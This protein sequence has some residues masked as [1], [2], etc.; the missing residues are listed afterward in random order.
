MVWSDVLFVSTSLTS[1]GTR[2]RLRMP[3][4]KRLRQVIV[5][6]GQRSVVRIE[7]YEVWE[8]ATFHDIPD[9]LLLIVM[10]FMGNAELCATALVCRHLRGLRDEVHAARVVKACAN[11]DQRAKKV[12]Q[13]LQHTG[14]LTEFA[15]Y[16]QL[17]REVAETGDPASMT[18]LGQCL[19]HGIGTKADLPQAVRM[20]ENAIAMNNH[21]AMNNLG[22]CY[23]KGQGVDQDFVRAY[24]LFRQSAESEYL[25]ALFN[26]G[27][28]LRYAFGCERNY[29]EAIAYLKKAAGQGLD[30]AQ[31]ELGLCYLRGVGVPRNDQL[32]MQWLNKAAEQK[33][34][35]TL[36]L[37]EQLQS[38]QAKSQS[39]QS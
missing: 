9:E 2:S 10:K 16:E 5:K 29:D 35:Y 28:C 11:G 32:A 18:F 21:M 26:V 14:K 22:V 25:K 39:S 12:L 34:D 19:V 30:F 15:A 6:E 20:Y 27:F 37:L 33:F 7:M 17:S 24:Q 4:R 23:Y 8:T 3:L 31:H 13:I 36:R 1:P 38:S